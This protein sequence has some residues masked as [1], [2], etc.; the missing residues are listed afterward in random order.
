[1]TDFNSSEYTIASALSKLGDRVKE[2]EAFDNAI[3]EIKTT[4][5]QPVAR[6]EFHFCINTFDS[7]V[8]LYSDGAWRDIIGG[9]GG[10]YTD[11]DAQDAVGTI[12]VDTASIDF[13]YDDLTPE[14][15]ADVIPGGVNHNS[16]LNYD[17]NKH[18]DH[19][20][21]TLTA[22]DGLT[23]GGTIAANRTFD[24]S[25]LGIEDLA[26]PGAD[27]I[28]FW[29]DTA[30]KSDWL[31]P[32]D[33]LSI[34]ALNL[35]VDDDFVLNTGDSIGGDLTYDGAFHPII[36]PGSDADGVLIEVTVTGTPQLI[37]DESEDS[38][39]INKGLILSSG[40]LQIKTKNELRF[41]DNG[42][43]VGF[44]APDLSADQIWVLPDADGAADEVLTTDGAGN[45]D[46]SEGGGGGGTYNGCKIET[47]T[48][49]GD[50]T[51]SHQINLADSGLEV[52][53]VRIWNKFAADSNT[54][55]L[56]ETT[57]GIVTDTANGFA[58]HWWNGAMSA[59]DNRIID[60]GTGY[61]TVDDDGVNGNPNVD[62]EEYH[63]LVLS[64]NIGSSVAGKI[65]AIETGT[66]T[67]DGTTAQQ[68]DLDDPNLEVK[69]VEVWRKA[70]VDAT[71][72]GST[73][74]TPEI[75]DW[76]AVAGGAIASHTSVAEVYFKYGSKINAIGTGFFTVDDYG[77][78]YPP[79][80]NGSE[81]AYIVFGYTPGHILYNSVLEN[82]VF[83]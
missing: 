69:Y 77:L 41:Y 2:L 62:G 3:F 49:T 79:N 13:T 44:E 20:A 14:I 1:M 31:V 39:S 42:N 67:G 12:L 55:G 52:A 70:T 47:G 16:L 78:N 83:T 9:G 73:I 37:W 40:D 33:H 24:V 71:A 4:T 54:G 74:T 10:G 22:G 15:T 53:Y 63:Y 66:Y 43:Y 50:G 5:G 28:Y 72:A 60:V 68:I 23:G 82:Q 75:M 81:Y 8:E 56:T 6:G 65:A 7:T 34:T 27:R 48:Y 21:V 25:I 26:D 64:K 46:W 30:S 59:V 19:T 11:E 18:I 80:E 35:N 57:D 61:F 45:L 58:W 36:A 17:A 32:N 51:T 76:D 38:F 29:D